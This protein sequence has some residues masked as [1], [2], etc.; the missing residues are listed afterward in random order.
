MT[1]FT[2]T[3]SL[4]QLQ[5]A[6]R[7][8]LKDLVDLFEKK[9]I[10]YYV[11]AG[12]LLGAVRHK[13][14][15]PWDDD[16]DIGLPREDYERFLAFRKEWLPLKY[17]AENYKT[18]N[19]YKY[20]ITRVYNKDVKVTELRGDSAETTYASVDL[21]PMDGT[22]NNKILRTIFVYKIMFYRM[23]ASLANYENIDKKRKRNIVE[24]ILI[25]FFKFLRPASWLNQK[26][27]YKHIDSLL[28]KQSY[29]DS[30]YVGSLMGAYRQKEIFP[31]DYIG[32]RS[33]YKFSNFY[34]YGPENSHAYLTHMYGNYMEI[35]DSRQ[36][37]EKQHFEVITKSSDK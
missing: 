1:N 16:L 6:D 12:S 18:S 30:K 7:E 24:K 23:L 21:F 27:I 13:D 33:R 4:Q 32:K 11:I 19:K 15:I 14:F 37:E 8:T 29:E 10:N 3:N 31:K 5:K 9:N 35:P 34:V 22:P 2:A 17:L 20:Y 36:I 25:L 26:K 28:K